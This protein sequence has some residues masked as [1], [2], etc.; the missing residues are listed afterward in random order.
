MLLWHT[1][2]NS[3]QLLPS[4]SL[5]HKDLSFIESHFMLFT[6]SFVQGVFR[7]MHP[8]LHSIMISVCHLG[9][10]YGNHSQYTLLSCYPFFLH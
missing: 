9:Q 1:Y 5:F 7:F 10:N 6:Q 3:I 2:P 4:F 8:K